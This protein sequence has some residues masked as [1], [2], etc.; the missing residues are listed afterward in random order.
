[1]SLTHIRATHGPGAFSRSAEL[2]TCG[3][4]ERDGAKFTTFKYATCQVCREKV[5]KRRRLGKVR[6]A[7]ERM[8]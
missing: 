6:A 2:A 8:P 5:V 1:M 4:R 3:A 7:A